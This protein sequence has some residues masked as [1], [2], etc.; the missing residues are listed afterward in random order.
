MI[1]ELLG[2]VFGSFIFLF[3][4]LIFCKP[5]IRICNFICRVDRVRS[6]SYYAFKFVNLSVFA[7]HEINVELHQSRRIPMGEGKFNTTY[8]R[9]SLVNGSISHVMARSAKW[10]RKQNNPHCIIVR[11][12]ENLREILEDDFN[13]L[14]LRVSL[15]HGLT[16]LLKVFEQ[17]YGN[18][19]DIKVGKFKPGTRFETI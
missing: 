18:E 3:T 6:E 9:K 5:K 8:E 2:G 16:G 12:H 17:E 11:T 13:C 7:A 19:E 1:I 4:V 15:K 14:I 10:R